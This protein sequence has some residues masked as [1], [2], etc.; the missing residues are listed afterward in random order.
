V[1][2]ELKQDGREMDEI[3][4]LDILDAQHTDFGAA[5]MKKWD[6]SD[7]FVNVVQRHHSLEEETNPSQELLIV[8]LANLI[9]RKPGYSLKEEEDE[10]LADSM[11]ARELGVTADTI[12]DIVDKLKVFVSGMTSL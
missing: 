10:N 1:L 5:L 3:S 8:S 12:E 11:A 9:T 6:L 2:L 4:I 7:E